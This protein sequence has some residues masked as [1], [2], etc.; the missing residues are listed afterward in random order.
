MLPLTTSASVKVMRSH[1]YCHFEIVLSVSSGSP[2]L[3]LTAAE[4]DEARKEAARL[5]DKAVAQYIA[6]KEA[7]SLR[8][9]ISQKW[10]LEQATRTPEGE[11]TPQEK[12]VIKYHHDK[13]FRA[14]FDYDYEDDYEQ[15]SY[16]DE[17]GI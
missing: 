12:A 14:R 9:N 15:P 8:S 7:Q 11:R 13:A 16:D 2:G 10:M 4:I 5:A 6:A 17:E 1:D 3:T